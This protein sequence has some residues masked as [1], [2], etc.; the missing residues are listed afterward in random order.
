MDNE[1]WWVQSQEM[2]LPLCP[3][4]RLPR[5]VVKIKALDCFHKLLFHLVFILLI[6]P[7]GISDEGWGW[8]YLWD[9]VPPRR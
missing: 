7:I 2:E 8:A 1:P 4:P 9:L 5:V 3:R 6:Q